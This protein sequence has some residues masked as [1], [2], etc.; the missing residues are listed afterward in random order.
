MVNNMSDISTEE[1]K[2]AK[3]REALYNEIDAMY[4][5]LGIIKREHSISV[6]FGENNAKCS[7]MKMSDNSIEARIYL[8][9]PEYKVDEVRLER[10]VF[11][12]SSG[13]CVVY[14]NRLVESTRLK[15]L[16]DPQF[17]TESLETYSL[18]RI[19][20]YKF[21]GKRE[22]ILNC[23]YADYI[24]LFDYENISI[25][26][27]N[28]RSIKRVIIN[29][30]FERVDYI[31]ISIYKGS[32]FFS[33]IQEL[34]KVSKY[35]GWDKDNIPKISILSKSINIFGTINDKNTNRVC[36]KNPNSEEEKKLLK[37][38]LDYLESELKRN[39][40]KYG[41]EATVVWLDMNNL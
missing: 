6:K 10:D 8:D 11:F 25:K 17:I 36:S 28:D 27:L 13:R 12:R 31:S 33:N 4:E 20:F 39:F 16:G 32:R 24:E 9:E 3:N 7:L 18:D 34:E 23:E 14:T 22:L 38:I 41:V 15:A 26:A 35:L 40:D 5:L 21:T 1:L 2:D 19:D 29:L 30:N 37:I